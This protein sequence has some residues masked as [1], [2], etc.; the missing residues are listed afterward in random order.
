MLNRSRT[1]LSMPII[2]LEEGQQIGKIR[3]LVVDPKNYNIAAIIIKN[4]SEQ[5]MTKI[6]SP[7]KKRIR[8]LSSSGK[9]LLGATRKKTKKLGH[10]LN[11]SLDRFTG[12]DEEADNKDDNQG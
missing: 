2:S 1:L 9:K 7:F 11:D 8:S 4:H 3:G 10:S 12:N 5:E 6:A